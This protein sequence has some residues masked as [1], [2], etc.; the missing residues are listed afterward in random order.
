MLPCPALAS[1]PERRG[2]AAKHGL[3]VGRDALASLPERRGRAAKHGPCLPRRGSASVLRTYIQGRAYPVG[4]VLR[5]Y[6]EGKG[7][8]LLVYP[9][10][11]E[12]SAPLCSAVWAKYSLRGEH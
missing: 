6:G 5:T 2:R 1:L 12:E 8:K 3:G 9:A 7:V 10:G 4:E 11:L